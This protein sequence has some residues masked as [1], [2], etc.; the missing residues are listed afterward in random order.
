M[1]L[2]S[3]FVAS[4][5][6][7]PGDTTFIGFDGPFGGFKASGIGREYGATGLSQYIEYQTITV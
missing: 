2:R 4:T 1:P 3:S 6:I 5:R 7:A